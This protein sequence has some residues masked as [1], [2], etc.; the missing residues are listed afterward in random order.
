LIKAGIVG[1]TGYTGIELLR[2]LSQ[3]ARVDL[4]AVTA[5]AEAGMPLAQFFPSL[6]K[7]CDHLV[8]SRPDSE[9]LLQ[10]DV[11][12]F[13][14]PHGV[15]MREVERLLQHKIKVIDLSADFRLSDPRV[16]ASCY[17]MEHACPHLL[18]EAVYGL[19]EINRESIPDARLIAVPGCYPTAVQLGF[20][21]LMHPM[22]QDLCL[23][24]HQSL[25][26]D[27]KSGASGAGRKAETHTLLSEMAENFRAYCVQAHRHH[28]EIVQG[29]R[30]MS[31]KSDLGLTFVPHLAPMIRG[32]YATLYAR[33][34]PKARTQNFQ[35]LFENF[36]KDQSFIDVL[37][38]G[39]LPETRSVRASN[40]VQI[41]VFRPG[42]AANLVVLVVE[43]NLVKGAAGQAVQCMNVMF[44]LP[45]STG[46]EQIAIWP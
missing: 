12:F 34:L 35:S 24:E 28:P 23:V 7:R 4:K 25:I 27:V 40:Q 15:A 17:G 32:I 13:A 33:I 43:D 30:L 18:A 39:G 26:A 2:L 3:H 44:G 41:A 14:T 8:F 38:P 11:V 29:L 1:G 37:E 19:V 9:A 42:D 10:C 45:E 31:G 22:R 6:R 21:P 16:F 20:A 46:L 5:R 36:Y